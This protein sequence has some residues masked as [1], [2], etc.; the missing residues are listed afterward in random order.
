MKIG[1][2]VNDVLMTIFFFVVGLE[3]KREVLVGEMRMPRHAALAIAAAVGG[4]VVPAL[5]F[6]A[7]AP[8]GPARQGWRL[9]QPA[10]FWGP[11]RTPGEEPPGARNS[12][13]P[14]AAAGISGAG[15]QSG[16][17]AWVPSSPPDTASWPPR[18]T[19]N[20]Q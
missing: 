13:C 14:Q 15:A 9:Q 3:I 10:R 20:R 11:H 6:L 7:L 12:P 5:I 2:V 8:E 16:Y 17:R 1:F 18:R 19:R 4:V